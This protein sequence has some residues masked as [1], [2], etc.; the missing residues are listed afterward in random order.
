M[1]QSI[2]N[3]NIIVDEPN[4]TIVLPTQCNME[5]SFCSWRTSD[6][7]KQDV[8]SMQFL[9][10]LR[11]ILEELPERF[12]QIT[13]SG[14]E[15]STY[16]ELEQVM[17]MI[18]YHK[19]KNIKK[20]V[21]TTN[22]ERLEELSSKSWFTS[23]V[24]Y[25]NLSRHHYNDET[26]DDI[27]KG[28]LIG[29]DIIQKISSTL[30]ACGIPLNINCV[31]SSSIFKKYNEDFITDFV[32]IA[33]NNWVNTITFRN[34]YDDG[35]GVHYLE[36]SLGKS[37]Q[38]NVCPV[39][40][41][42]QYIINGMIV[43]FTSSVVEPGTILKNNLYELI[44][45][46]NSKLTMD[47]SGKNEINTSDLLEPQMVYREQLRTSPIIPH[48]EKSYTNFSGCGSTSMSSGCK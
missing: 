35:N 48:P 44:L 19:F 32:S 21:F 4:F 31:L 10:K 17:M 36:T 20:V 25:V 24:D 22:G 37:V 26:N 34:D 2:N 27:F 8:S 1:K 3:L 11:I 7:D 12:S 39:C 14:G 15:P 13:I 42:T 41:K 33:K 9:K 18:G 29:W 40:R 46:P 5:C 43:F 45:Q 38:D 16:K 23:V 30:G 6:Q 47:W 28:K